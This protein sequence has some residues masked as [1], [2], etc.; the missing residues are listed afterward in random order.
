MK[1]KEDVA[2]LSQ[3][4]KA[5]K[6]SVGKLEIAYEEK[7]YEEFNEAKKLIIELQKKIDG[8]LR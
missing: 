5:M 4:I 6:E 3:L 1:K 2:I 7:N 8:V